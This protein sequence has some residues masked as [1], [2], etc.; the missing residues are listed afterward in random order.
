MSGVEEGRVH[1]ILTGVLLELVVEF[2]K[3]FV[4]CCH[5]SNESNQLPVGGLRC[6]QLT[7][8]GFNI[9]AANPIQVIVHPNSTQ[10]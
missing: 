9:L 2:D 8:L 3:V 5:E 6:R 7:V 4:M 10:H 1:N